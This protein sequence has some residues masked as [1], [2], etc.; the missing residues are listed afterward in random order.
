MHEKNY[1]SWPKLCHFKN[2]N[3]DFAYFHPRLYKHEEFEWISYFITE[4]WLSCRT[5]AVVCDC[6]KYQWSLSNCSVVQ[7]QQLDGVL[8]SKPFRDPSLD[9]INLQADG[10]PVEQSR[11]DTRFPRILDIIMHIKILISNIK[12][13]FVLLLLLLLSRYPNDRHLCCYQR[14]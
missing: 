11:P 5:D 10:T 9:R 1:S 13:I 12:C 6:V 8:N 4:I 2:Q 14:H 3:H 7:H